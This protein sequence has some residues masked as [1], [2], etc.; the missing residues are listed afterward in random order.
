MKTIIFLFAAIN[1]AFP[2]SAQNIDLSWLNPVL[3]YPAPDSTPA[4]GSVSR[5]SRAIK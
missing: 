3:T 5:N 1:V 2:S 4:P